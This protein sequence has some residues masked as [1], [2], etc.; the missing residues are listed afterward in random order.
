MI[1]MALALVFIIVVVGILPIHYMAVGYRAGYSKGLQDAA[2]GLLKELNKTHPTT[3]VVPELVPTEAKKPEVIPIAK[4]E[5]PQ[6]AALTPSRRSGKATW[7]NYS[8]GG[9]EW[10][11]SHATA[12]SRD[13]K[14]GSR[15]K[16]TNLATGEAVEVVVNDFG[17]KVWTGKIIDLSSYAFIKL[18]PL[19]LGVIDVMVEPIN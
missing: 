18:A 11:K 3:P 16:V 6:K 2:D 12:A 10:S 14:R 13:F 8:L 17:P 19:S 4:A 9:E 15:L 1:Y 5:E 7:Y